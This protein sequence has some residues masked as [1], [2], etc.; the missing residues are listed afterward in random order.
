MLTQLINTYLA[1][2]DFGVARV[3]LFQ[4]NGFIGFFLNVFCFFSVA[5]SSAAALEFG[6]K[7]GLLSARQFTD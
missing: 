4:V 3:V 1:I 7:L 5:S 2:P 6:S